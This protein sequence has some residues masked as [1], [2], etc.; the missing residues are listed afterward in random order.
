MPSPRRVRILFYVVLAVVITTLFFTS[1]MRQTREPDT[2]SIQDFYHKTLNAM[3][4]K[5]RT[6]TKAADSDQV[7]VGTKDVDDDDIVAKAM[8]ERLRQAEQIAKEAANAKAPNKPDKPDNIVGVGSSANGQ[9][10]AVPETEEE[11]A[12]ETE[13]NS[14]LKKSPVIIFSKSY[15]PYSKKAKEILLEKYAIDPVPFVVE[16]NQHPMGMQIQAK[17]ADMTGR[18]TVPNIMVNGKSIGGGDDIAEF[19]RQKTLAAKIKSF[20]GKRIEVVERP[21]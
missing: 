3:D 8:A 17:L 11:H 7:I 6:P 14:I 1:Q 10:D 19:A 20:G 9:A 15:C 12:I 21:A 2:R 16:L 18:S 4:G 5:P 13:L